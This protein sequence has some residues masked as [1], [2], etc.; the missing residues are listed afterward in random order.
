MWITPSNKTLGI[1]GFGEIGACFSRQAHAFDM[2]ILYFKR[3]RMS[4]EREEFFGVTYTP[5]DELLSISDYVASFV[6]FSAESEKM[7]GAREIG[8]LKPSAYFINCGRGKH[9]R[10]AGADRR[11]REPRLPWSGSGRL[12]H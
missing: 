4:P 9:C 1:I 3:T 10:R 11:T 8:L 5:L 7:L 12:L 6:P 2:D